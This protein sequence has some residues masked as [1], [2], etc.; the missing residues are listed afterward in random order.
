MPPFVRA[1]VFYA[2]LLKCLGDL[3]EWQLVQFLF[4]GVWK[5]QDPQSVW[6]FSKARRGSAVILI[7]LLKRYCQISLATLFISG[8]LVFLPLIFSKHVSVTVLSICMWINFAFSNFIKVVIARF[9]AF[10]LKV[11]IWRLFS[12]FLTDLLLSVSCCK[13]FN[14]RLGAFD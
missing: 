14:H 12:V 3:L 6:I 8:L 5:S 1:E 11:L 9:A 7:A 2:K 13:I 4:A 10:S